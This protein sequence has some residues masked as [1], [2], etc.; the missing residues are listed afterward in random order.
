MF[1]YKVVARPAVRLF[2]TLSATILCC[3]SLTVASMAQTSS[4]GRKYSDWGPAVN[5]GC[6]TINSPANDF[7]PAISKDGLSLYFSSTRDDPN[8]DLYVAQRPSTSEPWG[9][10][11]NLGPT[12]NSAAAEN[13]PAFSRDGHWMFFNSNRQGGFGDIDLWASYREHVHDDFAW[14]TPFNLGAG[15]NTNQFEAGASFFENEGGNAPLLFFGHGLSA[16][17]QGS[18]TDIWMSELL[19]DGT[20][21]NARPVPELNSSTGDQRPQIRFDCLE[22][23]FFSNRPGSMLNSSGTSSIDIW[24][25]TRNS[26]EDPWDTPVPLGPAVNS[27]FQDF[28]GHLS[29]DGLTL[30]FASTRPA[31][32]ADGKQIP[33]CGGFDLYKSTRIKLKGEGR[34]D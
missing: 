27:P 12:V 9:A 10:P 31:L 22:I 29:S 30:Y 26:V 8:G 18:T 33:G 16:A 23:F 32:D 21:G 24:V 25:A 34:R 13:N 15:V 20:F 4:A 14:Q 28:Q 5:L 11:Q 3:L 7:G 2:L 1:T 19:P 6:G 17:T